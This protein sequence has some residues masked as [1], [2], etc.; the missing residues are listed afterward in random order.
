M[1]ASPR[2]PTYVP[3]ELESTIGT[4]I[5][6]LTTGDIRDVQVVAIVASVDWL[7]V[8]AKSEASRIDL[9]LAARDILDDVKEK[10]GTIKAW[11]FKGY[12]GYNAEGFRWGTR[13]DSDIAMVSGSDANETWRLLLP[14]ATNVSRVDLAVTVETDK[15]I[16]HL[17]QYYYEWD[18]DQFKRSLK[19]KRYRATLMQNTRL[20][21]TLYIGARA[22]DQMGRVY[23][24]AAEQ[25]MTEHVGRLWRYEVEFKRKRALAVATRLLDELDLRPSI[26]DTIRATVFRWFDGRDIPPI[27]PHQGQEMSLEVEAKVTSD[28]VTLRWL[29][30]QVRP[31]VQRL[32]KQGKAT[33]LYDALGLMLDENRQM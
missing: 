33:A 19:D 15:A 27:F 1:C 24:K 12:T 26:A 14:V 17:L 32:L 5:H 31:S 25:G 21:Q 11:S 29:S 4:A 28:E 23:D 6:A 2:Y 8:T 3:T 9:Y 13:Q 20:G 30:S 10:R 7:T 22:S 16:P 18:D